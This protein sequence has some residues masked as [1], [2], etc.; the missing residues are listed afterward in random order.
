MLKAA[1]AVDGQDEDSTVVA[2][3]TCNNN[4]S[5]I[6]SI[7]SIHASVANFGQIALQNVEQQIGLCNGILQ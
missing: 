4:G 7:L 1:K 3:Q 6:V 2:Q 5:Y